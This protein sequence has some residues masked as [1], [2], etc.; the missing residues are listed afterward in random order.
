MAGEADIFSLDRCLVRSRGDAGK[1]PLRHAVETPGPLATGTG[2]HLAIRYRE[3]HERLI[4]GFASKAEAVD[5]IGANVGQV[6]E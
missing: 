3:G 6:K 1:S 2:W 5:W 4:E